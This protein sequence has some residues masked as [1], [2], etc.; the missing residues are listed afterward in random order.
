M[1]SI[2]IANRT[3]GKNQPPYVIAELSGN[4]NG[5]IGRA[6]DLI[7]LAKESGADAIK[8]QTYT[9]DTITINHRSDEFVVSGGL[10]DGKTLYELYDEAHTPWEWHEELFKKARDVGIT[11]FSSPFDQTAVEFLEKL[12]AP[13]YKIASFELIDL[14]LVECV[15]KTGKPLIISTG[16]SSEVEISEAL[17]V[18]QTA[19]AKDIILL[20]CVSG[21][22]APICEANLKMIDELQSRFSVMVGLSD[23]TLGNTAAIAAVAM[24]ACVIEKH[25][26]L[27]RLEGGVDSTF[28]LEPHELTE[29]VVGCRGAWSA[30][31]QGGFIRSPSEIQNLSFRRS[32]Y[33]VNDIKEGEKFT[34]DNV[35]SIRPGYGLPPK[36]LFQ[37]LGQVASRPLMRGTA[38]RSEHVKNLDS[39][40]TKS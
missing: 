32:L 18:A 30:I 10:W 4:H 16:M 5:D 25:F 8:I 29:L 1:R 2:K 28:S 17:E 37:I 6:L 22:P 15:A 33:I 34:L 35:R 11:I 13:A 9:A 31:G 26:T 27:S 12:N 14:P 39:T 19:G 20:H 23:H 7:G 36:F 38:L 40:A 24:G 21:Y 3:I